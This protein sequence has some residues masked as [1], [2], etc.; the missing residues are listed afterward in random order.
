MRILQKVWVFISIMI[1]MLSMG[2]AAHGQDAAQPAETPLVVFI[3][4]ARNLQMSSLTDP[5]PDGVSRLGDIFRRLGAEVRF[6]PLDV[7]LPEETDV[8]VLVR[9]R[10]ALT[11]EQLARIYAQVVRGA[12]LMLAIDPAGHMDAR[13][14]GSTSGLA[15][16]LSVDYGAT[17]LDGFLTEPWFTLDTLSD[18]RT[19]SL[20]AYAYEG[21]H[22]VLEPLSRYQ[23]PVYVWGARPLTVEAITTE[24]EGAPLAFGLPAFAETNARV[25]V[26][27]EQP[28][29]PNRRNQQPQP[30]AVFELNIGT[31]FQ[32]QLIIGAVGENRT[33]GTR[34]ALFGDGEMLENDFGLAVTGASTPLNPG[35]QILAERAAA[36]LLELEP[37]AFPPLPAGFSW[38]E[39][40]GEYD[41][42][43]NIPASLETVGDG[44]GIDIASVK[45]F[46]NSAY[47]YAFIETA[48]FPADSSVI[49]LD[50]D[51]NNDQVMDV[52]F[53]LQRDGMIVQ[54]REALNTVP[55]SAVAFGINGIEVRVPLRYVGVDVQTITRVCIDGDLGDCADAPVLVT[56]VNERDPFPMRLQGTMQARVVTAD[57]ANLRATPSTNGARLGSVRNGEL[58]SV[59][60][61]NEAG[62]WVKIEN[63]AYSAWMATFLLR[64]NGDVMTLPV[65]E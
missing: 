16:L 9:P 55:D 21:T 11:N 45:A 20:Q 58:F 4:E 8:I 12:N 64:L 51:T 65:V 34:L 40:D 2:I 56:T 47:L 25:W 26:G 37:A 32:G 41:E 19:S 48:T 13:T 43:A 61:R 7:A 15:R 18:V 30:P 36:W 39:M 3:E 60:G 49:T 52:T 50:F 62:D 33:T 42:W 1:L 22:P 29:R 24:S 5:G 6:V 54:Q 46:S 27:E 17:L 10:R 44:R 59:V 38:I 57:I 14:E 63:G 23:V 35:N 28:A 31:D 53:T